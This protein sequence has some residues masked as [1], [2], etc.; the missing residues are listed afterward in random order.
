MMSLCG[1]LMT[2]VSQTKKGGQWFPLSLKEEATA[3]SSLNAEILLKQFPNTCPWTNKH[4]PTVWLEP[5]VRNT[6]L[7]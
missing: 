6:T 5:I 4:Y 3:L 2:L 7:M 1:V